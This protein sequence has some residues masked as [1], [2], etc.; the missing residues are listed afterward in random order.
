VASGILL[1]AACRADSASATPLSPG[2]GNSPG[3]QASAVI[4]TISQSA[5]RATRA[6]WTPARLA[7]ATPQRP[8]AGLTGASGGKP[9]ATKFTGVPTVGA[10]FYTAGKAHHFCTASTLTS[11]AGNLIL[12]AAHCVYAGTFAANI[13]Y[14]PG[15]HDGH[16]P[17]GAWVVQAIVV[18]AGWQRSRDPGLDFAF[19]AVVAAAGTALP[20]QRVTGALSLAANLGYARPIEVIGY[21]DTDS[22]PVRCATK[23]FKFKTGQMEFYCHDYG[24]GTSG[25]PWILGYDS[26]NG[27]GAVF[28]VIGGYQQGGDREWSS[29]SPYF[30]PPVLIL[31]DQAEN[32]LSGTSFPIVWLWSLPLL[33]VLLLGCATLY[34]ARSRRARP[35]RS[36]GS[37]RPLG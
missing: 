5:Q 25:G 27:A 12:T 24:G 15:Y 9:T 18:A 28:G 36:A 21:N 20:I 13:E 3:P 10:L 22:E 4:Q 14:V 11:T 34:L 35:A 29:Y 33:G 2:T 26:H 30:G 6:F 37:L 31:L 23:S 32:A 1:L 17:Y 7:T 8:K 19:L 16:L